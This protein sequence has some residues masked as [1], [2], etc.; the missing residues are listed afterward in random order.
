MKNKMSARI[1]VVGVAVLIIIRFMSSRAA[2]LPEAFAKATSL[3]QATT[4]AAASGKPVLAFA[5]AE[6]CGPCQTLKRKAL[7]DKD[8]GRWIT[9]NTH[10][11]VIDGT[12]A[13]PQVE[14]LGV[15]GFPTLMLLRVGQGGTLKEVSRITGV[16]D[17]KAVLAFLS[18]GSGPVADYVAK[19]GA[20][21]EGY[22]GKK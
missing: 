21:P 22:E 8:V 18:A 10:A 15:T 5:T 14:S 16:A 9:D 3:E 20:Y 19:N 11:V 13:N 2:P 4:L 7:A 1:L 6:W 12:N 17:A